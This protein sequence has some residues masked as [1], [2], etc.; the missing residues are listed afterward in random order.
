MSRARIA[1]VAV[2]LTWMSAAATV[3][4]Q[5]PAAPG[6]QGGPRD[7][8]PGGARE[9][10]PLPPVPEKMAVPTPTEGT[11]PLLPEPSPSPTPNPTRRPHARP[12]HESATPK[13]VHGL[14]RM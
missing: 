5:I 11:E 9:V 12:H 2:A 3:V 8:R 14:R 7:E 10:V 4:A 6:G 1:A 13:P